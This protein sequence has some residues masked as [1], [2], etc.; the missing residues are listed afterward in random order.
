MMQLKDIKYVAKNYFK[1]VYPLPHG[2]SIDCVTVR[3]RNKTMTLIN[4]FLDGSSTEADY[5][6]PISGPDLIKKMIHQCGR[7]K[8]E[9]QLKNTVSFI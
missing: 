3:V 2:F 6:L 9:S 1:D 7:E 8:I 4:F 5:L